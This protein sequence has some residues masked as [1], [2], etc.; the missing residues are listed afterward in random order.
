MNRGVE[1]RGR[2]W[3][4]AGGAEAA[5]EPAEEAAGAPTEPGADELERARARIVEL[6]AELTAARE[7]AEAAQRRGLD[8]YRRALIAAHAGQLIEELVQG[9]SEEALDASV[10][11]ARAA[12]ERIAGL[13]RARLA[14]QQVPLGGGQRGAADLESLSPL[15]KIA[16]GLMK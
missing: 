5:E 14:E 12:Y 6:E 1:W 3:V 8:H 2:R 11:V 4:V 16:R 7:A 13:V 15:Q 10:E 9:S